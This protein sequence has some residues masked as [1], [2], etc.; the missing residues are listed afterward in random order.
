MDKAFLDASGG[1][2]ERQLLFG[3]KPSKPVSLNA[4][5]LLEAVKGMDPGEVTVYWGGEGGQIVMEQE[6]HC[7]ILMPLQQ[8]S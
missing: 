1:I 4:I 6:G 7:E 5:F 8:G 2:S 3:Q